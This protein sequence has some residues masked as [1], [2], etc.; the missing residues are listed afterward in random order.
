MD[1]E[2]KEGREREW[3]KEN[4]GAE[5]WKLKKEKGARKNEKKNIGERKEYERREEK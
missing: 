5:Q 4:F 2:R 3:R 1:E